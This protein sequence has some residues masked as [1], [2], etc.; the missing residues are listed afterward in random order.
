MLI[1]AFIFFQ[2][3]Q[4]QLLHAFNHICMERAGYKF[5]I[6]LL[7]LLSCFSTFFSECGNAKPYLLKI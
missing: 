7:L 5:L 1:L 4:H 6:L 2:H 3:L